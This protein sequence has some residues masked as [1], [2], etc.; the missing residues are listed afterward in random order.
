MLFLISRRVEKLV[1]FS[2][3]DR[4][5]ANYDTGGNEFYTVYAAGIGI[6]CFF[7]PILFGRIVFL[8]IYMYTFDWF[9]NRRCEIITNKDYTPRVVS[10]L[11]MCE[12][13]RC[14]LLTAQFFTSLIIMIGKALEMEDLI[15]K[16]RLY[17]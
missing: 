13:S 10:A 4:L 8:L 12:P 15:S 11:S 14:W 5:F 3:K 6:R 16:S 1:F 17:S 7:P 2:C 9:H